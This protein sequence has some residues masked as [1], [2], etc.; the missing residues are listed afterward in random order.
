MARKSAAKIK[1]VKSFNSDKFLKQPELP[2]IEETFEN[3]KQAFVNTAEVAVELSERID[4]LL[5]IRKAAYE[6]WGS[7]FDNKFIASERISYLKDKQDMVTAV[8][9]QIVEIVKSFE[10]E[11]F[12]KEDLKDYFNV[13]MP[14]SKAVDSE[15]DLFDAFLIFGIVKP[16]GEKMSQLHYQMLDEVNARKPVDEEE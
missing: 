7:E 16:W 11:E 10:L 1:P 6:F 9:K 4:N 15:R 14:K 5:N 8:Y 13:I 12:V 2:P 3:A